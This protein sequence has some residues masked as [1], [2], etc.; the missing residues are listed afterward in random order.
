MRSLIAAG[1]LLGLLACGQETQTVAPDRLT[2]AFG[3]PE[4][5][6]GGNGGG[7]PN[8]TSR[9]GIF[10]FQEL[11]SFTDGRGPYVDGQPSDCET[12]ATVSDETQARLHFP[13]PKGKKQSQENCR[14]VFIRLDLRHDGYDAT[15]AH[16]DTPIP[17][18]V[19]Y[20]LTNMSV[21]VD[22]LNA[23]TGRAKF[24]YEE[25]FG[26]STGLRYNL[27]RIPNSTRLNV[28]GNATAGWRIFSDSES[29]AGCVDND[30]PA[31]TTYWHVELDFVVEQGPEG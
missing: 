13:K 4:G 30:N 26:N 29:L 19:A 14:D 21:H 3:P 27:D 8:S 22:D 25:C 9:P 18:A 5:K 11:D 10:T 15:G 6:G 16:I 28:T 7:N 17:D 1:V 23:P 24:N 31:D 2:T 20:P 12:F